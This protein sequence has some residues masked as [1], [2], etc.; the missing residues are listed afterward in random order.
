[1]AWK[2]NHHYNLSVIKLYFIQS[3]GY[4]DLLALWENVGASKCD[5]YI[6]ELQ[7]GRKKFQNMCKKN[8]FIAKD[9]SVYMPI[10]EEILQQ[11]SS[12]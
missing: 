1:M 6:E 7:G 4:E 2:L 8:L 12:Y 10:L 9:S 3:N 11:A 5:L